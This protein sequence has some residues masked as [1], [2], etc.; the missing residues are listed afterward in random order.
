M[1]VGAV[2]VPGVGD[3][4]VELVWCEGFRER[5]MARGREMREGVVGRRW[6]DLASF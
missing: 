1:G 4:S 5:L 3:G 2:G 6:V